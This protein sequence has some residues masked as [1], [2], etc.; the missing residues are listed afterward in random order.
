MV[1]PDGQS[2][3][4]ADGRTLIGR[5]PAAEVHLVD[6]RVSRQHAQIES[7]SG[8]AVLRDLGSTNGTTVNGE[9]ANDQMLCDGDV[10]S[11]GGV[12]LHFRRSDL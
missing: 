4:L 3:L 10:V 12:E 5:D 7:A 6:S 1:L 8:I 9:P 11:L 2:V